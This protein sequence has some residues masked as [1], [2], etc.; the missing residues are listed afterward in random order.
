[1]K[2]T[3]TA[4]FLTFIFSF[5]VSANDI[6]VTADEAVEWHQN[7]QKIVAIGNAVASQKGMN[8]KADK[9]SAFYLDRQKA[10]KG[11]SKIKK[12]EA[13]GN[14]KLHSQS[15]DGFGDTMDY[16]VQ[17]DTMILVG[18]PAKIIKGGETITA[19]ESITYY[20]SQEKAVALGNVLATDKENKIHSDRMIAYFKKTSEDSSKTQIDRIEI[21]DNIKI[22]TKDAIVT[23]QRGIY[24][25][26]TRI[27]E[28]YDNVTIKQDGNILNGDKAISNLNTGISRMV[29]TSKSRKVKGVFKEKNKEK[30]SKANEKI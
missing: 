30:K 11:K 7:E 24:F 8:I 12:I 3:I 17:Q 28:L 20:P 2:K 14:V 9:M 15:A 26:N 25:P 6:N 16:D 18:K 5:N 21:F 27:V 1:M 23:S 29:S 13:R 10:A 22:I 4:I 19:D